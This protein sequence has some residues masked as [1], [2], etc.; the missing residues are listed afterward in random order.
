MKL[1][2]LFDQAPGAVGRLK[3][4]EIAVKDTVVAFADEPLRV[5]VHRMA[6]SGFTRL[7]VLDPLSDRKLVGMISL[8]GLL[9]ARSQN[10]T[11][12]RARERVLRIR[13]PFGRRA[14]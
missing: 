4:A 1:A 8:D 5:V 10:L 11:E 3:L 13:L 9:S 2:E 14:T 12:E 6:E 7:P